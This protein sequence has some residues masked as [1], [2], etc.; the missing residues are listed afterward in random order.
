MYRETPRNPSAFYSLVFNK[1][2]HFTI[3]NI[4]LHCLLETQT[5]WG[6]TTL[7]PCAT[8]HRLLLS[9][10]SKE[11][12]FLYKKVKNFNQT[13]NWYSETLDRVPNWPDQVLERPD[14]YSSNNGDSMAFN[15]KLH[16]LPCMETNSYF[17]F[18]I[19]KDEI[20]I[21]TCS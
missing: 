9:D 4:Y 19:L 13:A 10:I 8:K 6:S 16:L 5:P 15:L 2:I 7:F 17:I 20:H 11:K 1:Q 3:I 14:R 18:N 12:T 21:L